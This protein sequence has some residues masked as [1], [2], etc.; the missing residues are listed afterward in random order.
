MSG[1]RM[2]IKKRRQGGSIE[3]KDEYEGSGLQEEMN[4]LS[5][6]S[7]GTAFQGSNKSTVKEVQ[8]VYSRLPKISGMSNGS[9]NLGSVPEVLKNDLNSIKFRLKNGKKIPERAILKL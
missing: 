5:S 4:L 3:F 8:D 9:S 6:A 7:V 2:Q 1:R